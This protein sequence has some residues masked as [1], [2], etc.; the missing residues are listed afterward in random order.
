MSFPASATM[1]LG[2]SLD[3][4]N[5]LASEIL[6]EKQKIARFMMVKDEN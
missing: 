6:R 1:A 2:V 5:F 3:R 4:D